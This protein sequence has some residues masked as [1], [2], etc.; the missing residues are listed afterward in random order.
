[1]ISNIGSAQSFGIQQL[2]KTSPQERFAN[3]DVDGSDGL[4]LE[5]Y[6]NFAPDFVQDIEGSFTNIDSNEDGSLTES[7]LKSFA[8]SREAR[9]NRPPPPPPQNGGQGSSDQ[10]SSSLQNLIENFSKDE[11]QTISEFLSALVSLQEES[12]AA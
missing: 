4:S 10:S 12:Q 6:S 2:Q 9:G 11:Q 8:E 7:E 1:M 3:A 5:E